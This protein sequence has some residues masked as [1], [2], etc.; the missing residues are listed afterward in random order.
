MFL[1]C[2]K[3]NTEIQL[4]TNSIMPTAEDDWD[5]DIDTEENTF[6]ITDENRDTVFIAHYSDISYCV[7]SKE[8]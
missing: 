1:V 5:I 7:K 6:T 3:D 4:R 8:G 2:L